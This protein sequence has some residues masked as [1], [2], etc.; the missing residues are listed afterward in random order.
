[1]KQK[2]L[3]LSCF[4]LLA[5]IGFAQQNAWSKFYGKN[6]ENPRERTSNPTEY[7][8]L[9]LNTEVLLQQLATAPKRESASTNGINI[10]FPNLEGTFD[11]YRIMEASTMHP[12]LQAKYPEIRSYVGYKSDDF[13]TKIRF[14]ISPKFG[15][16]AVI[17]STEGLKYIDSYSEDNSFYM[18]YD[19]NNVEHTHTF[20]CHHDEMDITEPVPSFDVG[21]ETVID[22]KLRTYRTAIA[23][24]IE[25]TA[26]IAQQAGVGSGTDEQKK[27]AVME[28]IN[29]SVTRLN[30]VYENDLSVS[31]QLVANNDEIIFIHSDNYS[32]PDAYAMLN[33]NQTAIDGIIGNG[34]YDIGHVYYRGAGGGVAQL[35][36]VCNNSGKARGVTG[37]TVPVGDPFTIDYVAHEMGHQFG[38]NHTF[39]NSCQDNRNPSTA[40]EPGSAS[41]IMGYAGICAPNVQNRSDAYFHAVSIREM[42][43][44]VTGGG[45]CGINTDTGNREPIVNAGPDRTIPKETPFVLTATATDEDGDALTYNFEQ[46]DFQIATMPPRPNNTGGPMFRSVW[47]TDSPEKYF[48]RLGTI[49]GLTPSTEYNPNNNAPND[50]RAWEKL[51]AVARTMNFALLVRDNNPAGG[52]TGRDDVRLTVS[53]D[54]GPFLVT[55]Q[56]TEGIVWDLGQSHTITWDVANTNIAPVNTENVTILISTDGGLTFPHVLVESTPN[57]G[58]YTFTVPGGLGETTEGRIMIKGVD[59]YFLNVN[60][61]EI[62]INSNLSVNDLNNNS[63]TIYPN[64]SQGVFT[65]DFNTKSNN[66]SYVIYG[67]E[68]KL[69]TQNTLNP[70]GGK[71]SQQIN[72]SHLPSGTYVIQINNGGEKMTQQLIIKK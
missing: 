63:F 64:P 24:S 72:L 69:I 33:Q 1:M 49:V 50:F 27:E 32:V 62:T 3:L 6:I 58:S 55:S 17:R 45:N 48:P 14:S 52:Q 68:G 29:V 30:E 22:G 51:P 34:N 59:N 38:G 67:M 44:W 71:V 54:A 66:V 19:R 13:T 26:Y 28:A 47:Y 16:H 40:I 37:T 15:L 57:N 21:V 23:T 60:K 7:Q 20:N 10:K 18:F 56:N 8:L 2:F 42:Y 31:L 12:D 53:A 35:R 36:S 46:I 65:V 39:N 9:K 25:Y 70:T 43:T 41:T 11:N 5:G 61:A 4:L